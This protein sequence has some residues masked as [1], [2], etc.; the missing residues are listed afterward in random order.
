MQNLLGSFFKRIFNIQQSQLLSQLFEK[1]CQLWIV[2]Y[3]HE[4]GNQVMIV[5]GRLEIEDRF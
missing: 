5:R 3:H 1:L 4:C 2:T